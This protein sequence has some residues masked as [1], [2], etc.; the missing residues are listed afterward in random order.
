MSRDLEWDGCYNVRDLGGL[1]GAAGARTRWGAV[2]RC[3]TLDRL[4]GRGWGSVAAHG[5]RTVIDLRTPGEHRVGTGYRPD[6]LTVI[7]LP[8]DDDP[9]DAGLR[10][11]FGTPVYLRSLLERRPRRCAEVLAALA[12]AP[13][14]GVAVH[15]VAGRDRTGIIALLLL[16]LAGV[17]PHAI[18]ED[19]ER[20]GERLRPLYAALGE[21]DR[22]GLALG[23][24]A[25][26]GFDTRQALVDLAG[27]LDVAAYLRAAGLSAA[28]LDT[29][30]ARF[31]GTPE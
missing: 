1:A 17:D 10:E 5:V 30:R 20:S 21:V 22:G 15:C 9:A 12:A 19:Y 8:L 29:L 6:W 23:R 13:A 27:G 18:A 25:A 31:I 16:A 7:S 24:L 26:E 14:G 11:Y 4:S 2:V 3:D 28:D